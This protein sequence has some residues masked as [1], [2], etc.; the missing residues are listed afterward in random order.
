M[1]LFVLFYAVFFSAVYAVSMLFYLCS[2]CIT[3]QV[4]ISVEKNVPSLISGEDTSIYIYDII[5]QGEVGYI[6]STWIPIYTHVYALTLPK[7]NTKFALLKEVYRLNLKKEAGSSSSHPFP[8]RPVQLQKKRKWYGEASV[9][10]GIHFIKYL[11][12]DAYLLNWVIRCCIIYYCIY[13]VYH[14]PLAYHW[15]PNHGT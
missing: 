13:I 14:E 11:I 7:T 8:G 15:P 12:H 10:P 1:L 2:V 3:T 9:I 4:C 6:G 5:K